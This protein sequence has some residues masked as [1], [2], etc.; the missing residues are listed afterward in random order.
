LDGTK[1]GRISATL[2]L[3]LRNRGCLSLADD[4]G[5]ISREFQASLMLFGTL[6]GFG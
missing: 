6:G 1:G 3:F 5:I 4:A 2:A